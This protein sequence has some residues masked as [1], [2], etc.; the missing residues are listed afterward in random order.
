MFEFKT[1]RIIFLIP[2]H[3]FF[4]VPAAIFVLPPTGIKSREP[5]FVAPYWKCR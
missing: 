3:F 4:K 2:I 1:F 5:Q